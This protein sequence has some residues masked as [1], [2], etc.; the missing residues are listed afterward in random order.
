MIL[1]CTLSSVVAFSLQAAPPGGDAAQASAKRLP[2]RSVAWSP[3]GRMVAVGGGGTAI[4]LDA[5]TGAEL[6]RLSESRGLNYVDFLADGRLVTQGWSDNRSVVWDLS[7]GAPQE[8][9]LGAY[10]CVD[11][12]RHAWSCDS[13]ISGVVAR[14]ANHRYSGWTPRYPAAIEL[15]KWNGK[16]LGRVRRV[17]DVGSMYTVT[18]AMSPSGDI[19]LVGKHGRSH[20]QNETHRGCSN[21]TPPGGISVRPKDFRG[22]FVRLFSPGGRFR[23]E[24]M[25]LGKGG[26]AVA[27]S[28]TGGDL[29]VGD[30]SGAVFL[31]TSECGM[32]GSLEGHDAAVVGVALSDRA[33]EAVTVDESGVL[34]WWD[35]RNEKALRRMGF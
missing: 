22:G 33:A 5:A 7:R 21:A 16:K 11:S 6:Q 24:K 27:F 8:I 26:K 2:L 18:V 28:E 10:A 32:I 23:C 14:Y 15:Q 30:E 31:L 25:Q 12:F 35:L 19:A 13:P 17:G 4:L 3:D 29:I 1:I 34:V 9:V 20:L